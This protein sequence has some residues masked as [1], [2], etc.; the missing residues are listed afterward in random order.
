MQLMRMEDR[1]TGV[2]LGVR[3]IGRQDPESLKEACMVIW[4]QRTDKAGVKCYSKK[5]WTKNAPELVVE[6][7]RLRGRKINRRKS[8]LKQV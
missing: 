6:T 2:N 4:N 7:L 1:S 5:Q 8:T 3:F